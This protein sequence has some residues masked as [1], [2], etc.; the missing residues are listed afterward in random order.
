MTTNRELSFE[1]IMEPGTGKA[2]PVLRGQILRLEQ[3]AN[4]QVADS[5]FFNLHD[6]KEYFH[7]GRTRHLHGFWP[8]LGTHLWSNP[9]RERPMMT[10]IEDSFGRNS[11]LY[12]RCSGFVFEYHFGYEHHTNCADILG[13]SIREY[14]LTPDDVH[15][16][17]NFWGTGGVDCADDGQIRMFIEGTRATLG[18]YIHVLAQIDTLAVP[19]VCGAD[20]MAT[21]NFELKPLRIQVFD[22]TEEEKRRW[23]LPEERQYRNQRDRSDFKVQQIKATPELVRDES[24]IASWPVFP[25]VNST[26]EVE[27][28]DEDYA[29]AARA[30]ELGHLGGSEGEVVRYGFFTWYVE[31]EMHGPRHFRV[32][33]PT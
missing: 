3:V 21:S 12:P 11:V 17:F 9:P 25:L 1:H 5:N 27:L 10:I 29:F 18:D 20:V 2:V 15:D 24:Y 19:C 7:A 33:R 32:K 30:R 14:E 4:G 23:L 6:Y 26:F 16:S 28:G 13:E 8:G 31:H 22:A